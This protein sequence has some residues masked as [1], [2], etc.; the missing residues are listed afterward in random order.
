MPKNC[1]GPLSASAKGKFRRAPHETRQ[2][3][4][5]LKPE[6]AEHQLGSGEASFWLVVGLEGILRGH[7]VRV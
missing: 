2:K 7:P 1:A 6:D 3:Q 5:F 4:A